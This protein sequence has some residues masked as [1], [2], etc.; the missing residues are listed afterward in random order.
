MIYSRIK[1]YFLHIKSKDWPLSV[2]DAVDKLLHTLSSATL[3][4]I[5]SIRSTG[6]IID[7]FNIYILGLYIRNTFGMYKGNRKL[8]ESCKDIYEIRNFMF[9]P[10]NCSADDINTETFDEG[11]ASTVIIRMLWEKLNINN[12]K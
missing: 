11:K 2:D 6:N 8:I 9:S 7:N 1:N 3:D 12:G 4:E 5:A 10:L